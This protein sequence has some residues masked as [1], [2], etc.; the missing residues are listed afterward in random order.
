MYGRNRPTVAHCRRICWRATPSAWPCRT[1]SPA[2][3]PS[4]EIP[5]INTWLVFATGRTPAGRLTSHNRPTRIRNDV[6][7][8]TYQALALLQCT[9][10]GSNTKQHSPEVNPQSRN[11]QPYAQQLGIDSSNTAPPTGSNIT[12]HPR[13]PVSC[14]TVPLK[15]GFVS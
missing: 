14:L 2:R 13:P 9:E 5:F 11:L 10:S 1:A 8:H 7:A 12:S 6:H 15:H 4:N 3:H